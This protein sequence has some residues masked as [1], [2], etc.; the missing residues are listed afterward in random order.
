[1]KTG[2]SGNRIHILSQATVNQ[3][4]AGEVVER[5]ASVV[6]ELVENAI[7]AGARTIRI[8]LSSSEKAITSIRVTD[9]G[10]GMSAA[11][12][13]LAFTPHATSKI[14]TIEDLSRV[15]TLGF[16]GEALASIAAVAKVTLISKPK[17][18]GAVAGTRVVIAGGVITEN[19]GAGAPEGTSVLVEELFFNTP[20]RKK[21]L[22]SKNTEIAH[23]HAIMEGLCLSHP[24]ISF[25]LFINQTEQLVTDRTTQSLDTIARLYGSETAGGLIPV[26]SSLPFIAI[27]GYISRPALSRKDNTRIFVS[28]NGRYISSVLITN[29]VKEGY[30]TLLPKDRFP[31]AFLDLEIDTTLV[32]VN[33]HPTKKQ[34]RFTREK[35]I[36][37][38][39]RD[40]VSAALLTHDLIPDAHTPG[41][42]QEREPDLIENEEPARGYDFSGPVP[43]GVSEPTHAG[44]AISDRRLR[45]TEL[46]TG[47]T[48]VPSKLPPM[49]IIGQF[50]GIYLLATTPT[51]ELI[52]IDQHA[53]H[54]RILYEQVAERSGAEHRSQELIVPAILHRSPHDAA[55]LRELIPA[56][57]KEGVIIEEFGS[58]AFLVRAIPVVLGKLEGTTVIDDLVSDLVSAEPSRTVSDREKI[59][60]IIACRGAI[61]AGTVCT[62]EQCQRIINQLRLT[63]SPFTCPHGRPTMIRFSR[64]K[65]DEMFRRT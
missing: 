25:R 28:V 3:I 33:V 41:H 27:A 20:A 13:L 35:E 43:A 60:R 5:P 44:T 59:T 32:D 1:M 61:K 15:H 18:S 52:L 9:D 21:F 63:K 23:I 31:V 34:V 30:A 24:E 54:E 56:L 6:K 4:A 2:N 29:A 17:K 51:G 45:Q 14:T 65:L 8:E 47:L 48:P 40:A 39:I 10:S 55:L 64:A 38:A 46:V 57:E 22:K 37:G 36:T 49:E 7:D 19:A 50:G 12:A 58:G 42:R 62:Q 26:G 53:A 16:R 11:D